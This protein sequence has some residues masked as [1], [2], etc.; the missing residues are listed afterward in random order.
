MHNLKRIIKEA[1]EKIIIYGSCLAI[2]ASVFLF[3][4]GIDL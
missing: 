4:V 2:F 3:L 1:L